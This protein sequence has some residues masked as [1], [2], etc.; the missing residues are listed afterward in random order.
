MTRYSIG[1]D[2]GGTNTVYGLVSTRG[3]IISAGSVST[4]E[5]PSIGEYIRTLCAGLREMVAAAGISSAQVQGIGVGAPCANYATGVIEAATDLPWPSPIPLK[6][7][8]ERELGITVTVTNDA[9]AATEGER[10]YGAARGM[11][12]F[13]MLTLG[14]GVGSGIVCNG[15]LLTGHRGFAGELGHCSVRGGEGRPC[16]CGRLDCLQTFCSAS[17][18]VSTARNVLAESDCDSPMR[19]IKDLTSR[20]VFDC[21]EMGDEAAL[22]TFRR[23]GEVLGRTCADFASFSDPE[24]IILFGGVAKAIKYIRPAMEK[25]FDENALHLY[26]GRVRILSSSLPESESAILGA[27]ALVWNAG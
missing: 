6:E 14:T 26:R 20:D 1:I 16:G 25:A 8:L 10:S 7:L 3:E 4:R 24:A 11:S 9:N 2:I 13:M 5:A 27:S 15:H 18:V 12:N 22:E 17:G 23:T 19:R 21:A